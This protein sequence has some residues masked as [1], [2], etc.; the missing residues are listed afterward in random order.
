MQRR[1]ARIPMSLAVDVAPSEGTP[2]SSTAQNISVDGMLLAK[3]A[4]CLRVAEP[5]QLSFVL[6]ADPEHLSF[7][8]PEDMPVAIPAVVWRHQGNDAV[9]RFDPTHPE[10]KTIQHWVA[11]AERSMKE[12]EAEAFSTGV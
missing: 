2:V 11:H 6:P 4:G 5:V 10:R 3:A 12:G 8:L 7:V 1:Y 9:V